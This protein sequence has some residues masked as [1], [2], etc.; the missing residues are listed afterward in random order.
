MRP[1]PAALGGVTHHQIVQACVRDEVE[2]LEQRSGRGQVMIYPLYQYSPAGLAEA[3]EILRGERGVLQAEFTALVSDQA[4]L[5]VFG[6]GQIYQLGRGEQ[7]L[8]AGQCL[9]YK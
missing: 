6:A 9:A 2:L 4:G 8:E 5:R 1:D 7:A 3:V